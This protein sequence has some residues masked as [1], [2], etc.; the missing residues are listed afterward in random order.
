MCAIYEANRKRNGVDYNIYTGEEQMSRIIMWLDDRLTA[1]E[2][3]MAKSV[4]KR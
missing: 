4:E 3:I 1:I 2:N